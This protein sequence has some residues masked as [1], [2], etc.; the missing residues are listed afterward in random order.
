MPEIAPTPR[1][2]EIA[3][4]GSDQQRRIVP[5]PRPALTVPDRVVAITPSAPVTPAAPGRAAKSDAGTA[6]TQDAGAGK[7]TIT[8]AI[9]VSD[10][11]YSDCARVFETSPPMQVPVSAGNWTSIPVTANGIDLDLRARAKRTS[12][13]ITVS[14]LPYASVWSERDAIEV[15][16]ANANAGRHRARVL[17][18]QCAR[19]APRMW[20]A[21]GLCHADPLTSAGAR[22]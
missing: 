16:F 4:S 9:D 11:L 17:V 15:R 20:L 18:A 7:I 2:P 1:T 13:G 19:T 10:G 22:A 8:V 6:A 3:T 5:K 14:L 21:L 12:D